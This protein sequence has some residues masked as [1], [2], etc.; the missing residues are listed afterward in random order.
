M[1]HYAIVLHAPVH[2]AQV[3]V[4]RR[5]GLAAVGQ[6][7]AIETSLRRVLNIGPDVN[8]ARIAAPVIPFLVSIAQVAALTACIEVQHTA[9]G[10]FRTEVTV[11][12]HH[13]VQDIPLWQRDGRAVGCVGLVRIVSADVYRTVYRMD[14]CQR[15]QQQ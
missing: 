11:T 5:E 2:L 1:Q 9:A 14:L 15:H 4:L 10:D 12:C 13:H 3:N 8:V 7:H 6:Y